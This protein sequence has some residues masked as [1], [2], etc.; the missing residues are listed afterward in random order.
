MCLTPYGRTQQATAA[1]TVASY[2]PSAARRTPVGCFRWSRRA[3]TRRRQPTRE[4]MA[5]WRSQRERLRRGCC[6]D[7]HARRHCGAARRRGRVGALPRLAAE[8][9]D[10]LLR[11]HAPIVVI[12]PHSTGGGCSGTAELISTCARIA[13][14]AARSAGRAGPVLHA[15]GLLL[16]DC[17][18]A[19]VPRGSHLKSGQSAAEA[20]LPFRPLAPFQPHVPE[21]GCPAWGPEHA[22]KLAFTV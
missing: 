20:G 10:R 15:A 13:L 12:A 4:C 7:A 1:Y 3:S 14:G 19:S 9:C 6:R 17:Q 2:A 16:G 21:Q 18:I 5:V 22:H 8:R 11:P